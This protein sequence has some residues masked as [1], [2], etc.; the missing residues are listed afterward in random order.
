VIG[1]RV[2]TSEGKPASVEIA[3]TWISATGKVVREIT[4]L[5]SGMP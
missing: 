2:S 1:K 5:R 3:P 4:R